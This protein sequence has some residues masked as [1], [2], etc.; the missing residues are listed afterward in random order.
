[1]LFPPSFLLELFQCCYSGCSSIG[2]PLMLGVTP[3]ELLGDRGWE[4]ELN[5]TLGMH[6]QDFGNTV[7]QNK[8]LSS[9][10]GMRQYQAEQDAAE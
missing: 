10:I 5:R 8:V 1:M 6:Q 3:S 2:C 7:G 4:N 9:A